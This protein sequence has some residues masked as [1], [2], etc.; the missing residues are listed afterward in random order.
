MKKIVTISII[1]VFLMLHTIQAMASSIEELHE[2]AKNLYDVGD[3][4]AAL[5]LYER[6]LD[7]NAED[8]LAWDLSAWCLRYLDDRDNAEKNYKRALELLTSDDI[9]WPMIGLGEIYMNGRRYEDALTC[10]REAL[11]IASG[12]E[13]ASGRAKRD[14]EIVLQ[15]IEDERANAVSE[16]PEMTNSNRRQATALLSHIQAAEAETERTPESQPTAE[17]ASSGEK[18][19]SPKPTK[20]GNPKEPAKKEPAKAKKEPSETEMK[21]DGPK[22]KPDKAK[23]IAEPKDNQ[24][25]RDRVNKEQK[26]K[27][28]AQTSVKHETVYGITLDSPI[29]TALKDLK[30]NGS[31][32]TGT[33]FTKDG[34]MYHQ[35][36]GLRVK[37]PPLIERG[38]VNR[39]YYA[40]SYAERVLSVNVELNY[41]KSR[42]YAQ[43]KESAKAEISA[44]VGGREV[45]GVW[46]TD[47]IFSHEI[48]IA[49]SN[50]YAIWIIVTDKGNGTC[51]ME[52]QHIDL[53]GL[54]NY[55][56]SNSSV[57]Y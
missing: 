50:T 9:V 24:P 16:K 11:G 1:A 5:N 44:L 31:G 47:H 23:V 29:D 15:K 36:R 55:W 52:I 40:V 57:A 34:K 25:K 22:A 20:P 51:R 2:R 3:Y 4:R 26:D 7:G 32:T 17:K 28:P 19:D 56:S 48:N 41:D 33:P 21:K 54:S 43:L 6:I 10:L 42:S 38:S 35:A 49:L 37:L 46:A 18:P 53:F 27:T 8:G 30:K 39:H 14:I 12:N 13:E 45:I